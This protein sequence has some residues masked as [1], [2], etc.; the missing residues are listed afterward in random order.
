MAGESRSELIAWTNDLLQISYSKV[1]QFGTGAA[2]CQILDSIFGDVPM[3]RVKFSAKQEYEYLNNFKVLQKTFKDHKIAK[4]IPV[5][6]LVKCKMQDNLEFLQWLRRF[7]DQSFGGGHYDAAGR[8]KGDV[9]ALQTSTSAPISRSSGSLGGSSG[10]RAKAAGLRPGSSMSGAAAERVHALTAELN[11][12]KGSVEG[13]ETERD[14]YFAKLRDIE[15]IV[16]E[17]LGSESTPEL[18]KATLS[19][20]QEILYSTEE[21]FEVPAD[22]ELVGEEQLH[23]GQLHEDETF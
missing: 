23:D 13:L 11:E 6:R 10:A 14:F 17:K 9:P 3:S 2:Y 1:E 19:K 22:A 12:L 21:G 4:P 16:Q 5:D 8:R 15:M 7:H 20:I 18:E